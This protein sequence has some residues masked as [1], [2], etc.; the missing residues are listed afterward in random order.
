MHKRTR[1]AMKRKALKATVEEKKGCLRCHDIL[2]FSYIFLHIQ[3][4]LYNLQS[5]ICPPSLI[6]WQVYDKSLILISQRWFYQKKTESQDPKQGNQQAQSL[7]HKSYPLI[8]LDISLRVAPLWFSI[9]CLHTISI[10]SFHL[11][12]ILGGSVWIEMKSNLIRFVEGRTQLAPLD[13]PNWLQ[14]SMNW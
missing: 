3:H 2:W 7:R 6:S 11:W 5:L 8:Q 10:I 4:L 13:M 12:C 1:M 14:P 9:G